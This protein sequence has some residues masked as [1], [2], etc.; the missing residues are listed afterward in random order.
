M[1][2][3]RIAIVG[4]GTAGW[5]A[6]NHL[7]VELSRDPEIT[8]TLIESKDVPI[9]GVGEGTVPRIRDTLKKF[10]ISELELITTCDVTFKQGIKFANWL[11]YGNAHGEN[12][13]Y[14][15]PFAPPYPFGYD[16][17]HYWLNS[18]NAFEFAKLS[19]AYTLSELKKSPKQKSSAPYE[20][21]VDYAYHFNAASFS[22]LLA[23][24]A[25]NKFSV[26]HKFETVERAVKNADGSIKSLMYASGQE[27]E[28]DFYIDCSG[29]AALLLGNTLNVPFVDKSKQI[30]TN[31]ALVYRQSLSDDEELSPYT[32]ATAH[33]A[34]W[35]WEI[36]LTSR[37]GCGFVYS[38]NFINDDDA[39]KTFSEYLGKDLQNENVRKIPMKIGYR[40]L[41]WEKNCVALGLAQGF[42]EPL[43][44]TSI[45]VTDFS[46]SLIARN[47]PCMVE[48]M[49]ALSE[50]CNKVA[51]YT[52]ERVIDFVQLHYILSDR[53]DSDFWHES[54]KRENIS[55]VLSDRL[56]IWKI[57]SP[58]KSDFFSRFDIFGPENYL[59]VLYGM[60]F[61]TRSGYL[62]DEDRERSKECFLAAQQKSFQMSQALLSHRKW[63]TELKK[64]LASQN[65]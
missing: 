50:Y 25:R 36:P 21:V 64:A 5:L 38:D 12:N 35:V 48:D 20:G 62:G 16:L 63:L 7:G 13:F 60:G 27:E 57:N 8:I 42:V 56:E 14:Y 58:K 45:L 1:K 49:P 3:K 28:F 26:K 40:N 55:D 44:A 43:E 41:F 52:W 47:F 11:D 24:N 30:I 65:A 59:Y 53:R 54:T 34:G 23:K 33:N 18:G 2:I 51:T 31:S 17:T 32:L 19:D 61:P 10:G 46:A 15:H 6:A 9:I 39:V 37:K 4:G 22:E 29:F